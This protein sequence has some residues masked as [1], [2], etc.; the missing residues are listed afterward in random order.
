MRPSIL[1]SHGRTALPFK[2]QRGLSLIESLVALLVL[3]LGVMGL[4]GVQGRMLVETRTSNARAV[5]VGLIDDIANRMAVNRDQALVAGYNFAWANAWPLGVDCTAAT[6]SNAQKAQFDR[7]VWLRSLVALLGPNAQA[8]IFSS[9]SAPGQIGI[10]VAWPA[11]EGRAQADTGASP[12][13]AAYTAPFQ[14][15]TG[16]ATVCPAASL[17]HL[18][19]VQP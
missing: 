7:N 2:S 6:C 5:A 3:T 9:P 16:T 13:D 8:T 12:I 11:N 17:C 14:V 19:Y 15:V 10:M 4:A 1:K 18:V